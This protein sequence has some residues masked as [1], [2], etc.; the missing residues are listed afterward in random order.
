MVEIP[1][2]GYVV[3]SSTTNPGDAL[4]NRSNGNIIYV[5]LQYRLGMFGFLGGSQIAQNGVRNAGL[6][7]QRA[8]LLFQ[9]RLLSLLAI[10]LRRRYGCY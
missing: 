8:A 7:D 5:Q 9:S 1:A 4:V 2:G 3:G 10:Q 6:L